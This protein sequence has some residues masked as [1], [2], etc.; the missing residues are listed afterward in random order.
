MCFFFHTVHELQVY[1]LIMKK[2]FFFKFRNSTLDIKGGS[3]K[4]TLYT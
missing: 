4:N 1:L 2:T 3:G